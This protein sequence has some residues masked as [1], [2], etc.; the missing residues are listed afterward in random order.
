MIAGILKFLP[1]IGP[2][3]TALANPWILL[4]LIGALAGSFLMGMHEQTI[5]FEAHAKV[6]QD[7]AI[8]DAVK[9]LHAQR[10]QNA[11][12][13]NLLDKERSQR[14]KDRRDFDRQLAAAAPLS[15]VVCPGGGAENRGGTG[16]APAGGTC[17]LSAD[18]VRL[19]N[20]GLALGVDQAHRGQFA[21]AAN[22]DA[23]P[24]EIDA[25]I[26]NVADN[27][28]LLGEC[29]DR[30]LTWQ[31]KACTNGWWTGD[32]C[33]DRLKEFEGWSGPQDLNLQPPRPK[34]GT[35]PN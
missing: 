24:A 13:S 25:A 23:G 3:F 28:E 21:D 17:R 9:L 6:A 1:G 16:P 33:P 8:A 4:A 19:W 12:L 11:K 34:R 31:V 30:E 32:P 27:A 10:E 18:G 5:R 35:L 2:A 20:N 7:A 15:E 14:A 22:A 26:G 29:R